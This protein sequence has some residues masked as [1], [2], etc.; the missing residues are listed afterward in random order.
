[1][2]A[3][4]EVREQYDKQWWAFPLEHKQAYWLRASDT[5]ITCT[6]CGARVTP[7]SVDGKAEADAFLE[8]H[9]KCPLGFGFNVRAEPVDPLF[10]QEESHEASQPAPA[11]AGVTSADLRTLRDGVKRLRLA[12]E[13]ARSK[14]NTNT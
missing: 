2:L 7:G 13:T 1:V 10:E 4:P 9:L 12:P 3:H 5:Q 6:R 8:Q 11:P 14:P